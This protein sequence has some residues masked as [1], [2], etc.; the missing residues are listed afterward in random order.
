VVA[1]ALCPPP[2]G[3]LLAVPKSILCPNWKKFKRRVSAVETKACK[4][5]K[6][7]YLVIFMKSFCFCGVVCGRKRW[8]CQFIPHRF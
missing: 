7:I 2:W 3:H 1:G 4:I 8:L 6:K 5:E